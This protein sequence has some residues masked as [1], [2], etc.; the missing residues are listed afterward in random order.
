MINREIMQATPSK[1]H[2]KDSIAQK[3]LIL[4][5]PKLDLNI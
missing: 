2:I 5:Q 1:P 3:F 4:H